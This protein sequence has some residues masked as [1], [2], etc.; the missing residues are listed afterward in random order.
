MAKVAKPTTTASSK[1]KGRVTFYQPDLGRSVFEAVGTALVGEREVNFT[2]S[3]RPPLEW[4]DVTPEAVSSS[5][6]SRYTQGLDKKE[7]KIL[8]KKIAALLKA[9]LP[10]KL[11][12]K[13]KKPT[14]AEKSV[15]RQFSQ[16]RERFLAKPLEVPPVLTS[17]EIKA[18]AG[19]TAPAIIRS[20]IKRGWV[21]EAYGGGRSGFE[22]SLGEGQLKTILKG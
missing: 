4:Y 9:N 18:P 6:S 1:P 14:S 2:Y 12:G 13:Q 21:Q 7:K 3:F 17:E 16:H 5:I 8:A 22:V 15:L 10:A 20:L 11:K 19:K